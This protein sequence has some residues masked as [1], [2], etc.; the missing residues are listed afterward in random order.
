VR[1]TINLAAAVAAAHE[2]QPEAFDAWR[3]GSRLERRDLGWVGHPASQVGSMPSAPSRRW[4][5]TSEQ[6]DAAA[7]AMVEHGYKASSVNRDLSALGSVYR[8]AK[9]RRLSPRAFRSPT[10]DVP[11]MPEPIRRGRESPRRNG[12]GCARGPWRSAIDG[13]A[14]SSPS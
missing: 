8:W 4:D 13:S 1:K 2:P 11:R 14:S 10:L 3:A 9:K 6:L 5:I 12:T 7:H